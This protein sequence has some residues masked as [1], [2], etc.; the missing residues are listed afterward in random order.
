MAAQI[1]STDSEPAAQDKVGKEIHALR[2]GPGSSIWLDGRI[3]D[4]PWQRTQVISDLQQE[5]PDNMAAPTETTTVRVAY[6]DRYI[7]VAMEM[8]MRAPSQATRTVVVS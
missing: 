3:D 5:D 2:V 6:D 4:E 7:Y 8:L 1:N